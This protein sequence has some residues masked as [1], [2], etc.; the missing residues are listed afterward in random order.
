MN[1]QKIPFFISLI[2]LIFTSNGVSQT[3]DKRSLFL[4]E[5]TWTEVQDF[6]INEGSSI[7]IPT[8]GTEQN[9]PHMVLGKHNIRVKYLADR[10]AQELG[11]ALV[12]PTIAYV[13]EG[14]INPAEGWMKYPGTISLPEEYFIKLLEYTCRSLNQHG[15][16]DIFLI[17]DSGG[18]QNGLKTVST[19]LN[20]EWASSDTRV[21]FV[22]EYYGKPFMQ[23]N[24]SLIAA[25]FSP[26]TVGA[27]ASIVDVS[28]MLAIDSSGVRRDKL[29]YADLSKEEKLE[30]GFSGDPSKASIKIGEQM[31][32]K[33]IK[34]SVAQMKTL[35]VKN[36]LKEQ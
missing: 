35:K 21:H 27:H 18:N 36:R 30:L 4:E 29:K 11:D 32:H 8:G 9:G 28:L 17:G 10:I 6:I 20:K 31:I 13:P 22:S 34:A 1:K 12:A 16:V 19:I 2:L 33:T 23:V 7:I 14:K 25:G 15:F 3:T 26:E 5:L 24:D